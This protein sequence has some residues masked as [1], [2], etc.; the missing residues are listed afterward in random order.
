MAHLLA[1]NGPNEIRMGLVGKGE[2]LKLVGSVMGVEASV[3]HELA[4]MGSQGVLMA[5]LKTDDIQ[6]LSMLNG[7]GRTVIGIIA[8]RGFDEVRQKICGNGML[9]NIRDRNGVSTWST[10]EA[11]NERHSHQELQLRY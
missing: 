5:L 3:A 10:M 1:V 9:L 8:E 7:S 4:A 6:M 11:H 2:I